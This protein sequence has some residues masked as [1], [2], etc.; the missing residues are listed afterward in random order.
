MKRAG[1]SILLLAAAGFAAAQGPKAGAVAR[2]GA[3]LEVCLTEAADYSAVYPAKVLPSGGAT[4]EVAA[5]LRLGKGESYS[6]MNAAWIAAEVPG[7]KPGFVINRIEM[8]LRGKD[9]AVVRFKHPQGLLAGKYRVEITAQGKPWKNSEFRLAPVAA[10]EVSRPT[11]LVALTPGT[12]RRY[13]LTQEFGRN[14]RPTRPPGVKLDADGRFRASVTETVVKADALGAHIETRQNNVLADEEWLRL[15]DAGLVIVKIRSG[16]EESS[17]DPPHTLW[18]WPL[19][20]P[21]EWFY[22]PEDKSYR[23][24]FRMWGPVA[25]KGPAGEGPGYVVLMEQ[26]SSDV[27]LSV[28]RQYL[29]GIG[30][31]RETITQARNGVLLTRTDRVLTAMPSRA[32]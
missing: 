17:F 24:R 32:P 4:R 7:T 29:P 14:V 26:P 23:Q 1:L 28:E 15:T 21:K 19:T 18:P 22:E 3:W 31:V 16:G 5:V 2:E 12:V 6:T 8:D 30:V 27:A 10:P 9:R 20:T 25:I 11:D 13:A